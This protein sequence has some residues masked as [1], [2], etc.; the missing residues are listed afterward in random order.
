MLGSIE[1]AK[2]VTISLK[3]EENEIYMHIEAPY[4][5]DLLKFFIEMCT[6]WLIPG[7]NLFLSKFSSVREGQLIVC[8]VLILPAHEEERDMICENFTLLEDEIK[9]GLRSAYHAKK[10]LELKGLFLEEK[11]SFVKETIRER[12]TRFPNYFDYDVFPLMQKFLVSVNEEY[13]NG[14]SYQVLSFIICTCYRISQKLLDGIDEVSDKRHFFLKLIPISESTPFGEKLIL[15]C[16]IGMNFLKDNEILEDRHLLRA[17]KKYCAD[18]TL[19]EGSYFIQK[20]DK[21]LIFYIEL[22]QEDSFTYHEIALLKKELKEQVKG[23]IESLVRPVFMPRNEEEVM[24]YIV[25]LSKQVTTVKD[26]PQIVIMFNEQTDENLIFTLVMVRPLFEMSP[27]IQKILESDDF[28]VHIE[29]V[30]QAGYI[31]K[32]VSKEASQIRICMKK[33]DYLRED[34]VVDLYMARQAIVSWL[35]RYLGPVRDYNGGMISRQMEIFLDFQEKISGNGALH[36][37]RLSNF[38]H[39]LYPIELRTAVSVQCLQEF[40]KL[41]SVVIEEDRDYLMREDGHILFICMKE[42]KGVLDTILALKFS[43]FK[44]LQLQLTIHEKPILG[45]VFFSESTDE[46]NIFLHSISRCLS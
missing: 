21:T 22:E 4:R 7:K 44:L 5:K 6:N 2:A 34:F 24:K 43:P 16:C 33:I 29:K 38:F 31:R 10:L 25:T 36:P 46:K 39:A 32:R 12:V 41:F 8:E 14:R 19:V 35:E 26:L 18:V 15:G 11:E 40:Y 27:Q 28:E 13:K 37:H 17:V 1:K 42:T 20:D 45:F 23:S 3:R 9:L 30:R